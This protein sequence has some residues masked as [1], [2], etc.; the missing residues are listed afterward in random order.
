ML[1]HGI[2]GLLLVDILGEWSMLACLSRHLYFLVGGPLEMRM[3]LI[4]AELLMASLEV[5]QL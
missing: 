1:G 2:R 4:I 3:A 5:E